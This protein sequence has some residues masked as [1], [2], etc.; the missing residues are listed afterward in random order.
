MSHFLYALGASVA[1][2]PFCSYLKIGHSND[3]AARFITH[4]IGSPIPLRYAAIWRLRR[5]DHAIKLESGCHRQFRSN[6]VHGEWFHVGLDEII[7]FVDTVALKNNFLISR[8]DGDTLPPTPQ[9]QTRNDLIRQ[10]IEHRRRSDIEQ[11]A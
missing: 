2:P 6:W 1:A 10:M 11:A 7:D 4:Q 5:R 9:F 8:S 3:T